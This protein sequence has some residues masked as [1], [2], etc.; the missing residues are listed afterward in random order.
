[1][2]A[3]AGRQNPSS[4][5]S[6]RRV[7]LDTRPDASLAETDAA[8]AP[9]DAC[10]EGDVAAPAGRARGRGAAGTAGRGR[11][12]RAGAG[13]GA[14]AALPDASTRVRESGDKIKAGR[15][16]IIGKTHADAL[17]KP[18]AACKPNAA[19]KKLVAKKAVAKKAAATK[20]AITLSA[21]GRRVK[22]DDVY[23]DLRKCVRD[24]DMDLHK[25]TSR[26]YHRAKTRAKRLGLSAGDALN[27]ARYHYQQA[28]LLYRKHRA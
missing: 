24:K 25:F 28:A 2:A 10:D 18:A 3:C 20:A 12:G 16:R 11:G 5:A 15:R 26:A 13:A 23:A 27:A 9:A 17:R 8:A 22:M 4:F 21:D 7:P 14:L 19:A 1:M 6:Q